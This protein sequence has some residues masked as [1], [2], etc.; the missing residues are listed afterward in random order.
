MAT[1]GRVRRCWGANIAKLSRCLDGWSLLRVS[2][3]YGYRLGS[4]RSWVR[5]NK[6]QLTLAQPYSMQFE[7]S[8]LSSSGK[9]VTGRRDKT[10]R[11]Q[12]SGKGRYLQ[13]QGTVSGNTM[14]L[15]GRLP[16]LWYVKKVEN[17]GILLVETWTWRDK[18]S[19]LLCRKG[20]K[21]RP[22]KAATCSAVYGLRGSST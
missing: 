12:A 20:C 4:I 2:P 1:T 7:A 22:S 11:L 18:A 8:G 10:T 6:L 3:K 13:L 17:A 21:S 14:P 9:C 15:L 5:G 19:A 16:R